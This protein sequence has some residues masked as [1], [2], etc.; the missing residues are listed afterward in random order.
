MCMRYFISLPV[1]IYSLLKPPELF[2]ID[3]WA[4]TQKPNEFIQIIQ[5]YIGDIL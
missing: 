3:V 5:E 2:S 1:Y 4:L